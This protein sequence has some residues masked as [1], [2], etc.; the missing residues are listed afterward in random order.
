MKYVPHWVIDALMSKKFKCHHCQKVFT[1][2]NVKALGIRESDVDPSKESFYI[3]LNC[4]GCRKLTYFEMQEMN[5]VELS[6]QIIEEIDEDL[7]EMLDE[8]ENAKGEFNEEDMFKDK[9]INKKKETNET[10]TN[11]PRKRIKKIEKKELSKITLKDVRDAKKILK[12][13][14]LKHESFLELMGMP[15]EEIAQYRENE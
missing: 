11:A 2:K 3:Q 1:H 8:M 14:D 15:P 4:V 12:P 5:I 13:K 6:E 9:K 10:F 7:D